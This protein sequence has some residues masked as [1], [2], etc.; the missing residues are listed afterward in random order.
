MLSS[1]RIRGPTR[2]RKALNLI[3]PNL[4]S[5][6]MRGFDHATIISPSFQG[7]LKERLA[8]CHLFCDTKMTKQ[9]GGYFKKTWKGV[10]SMLPETPTLI[11]DQTL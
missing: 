3:I 1:D 4:S 11:S 7:V 10:C 2:F 6:N 5:E 9:S 8:Q